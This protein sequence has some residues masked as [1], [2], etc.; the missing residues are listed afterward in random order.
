MRC[1]TE[2][3]KEL[4]VVVVVVLGV[5]VSRFTVEFEFEFEFGDLLLKKGILVF[6]VGGTRKEQHSKRGRGEGLVEAD[7]RKDNNDWRGGMDS[8]LWCY[9]Y[10][11]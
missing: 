4:P 7:Q 8:Y 3:A 2:R 6:Q 9:N 11:R 10:P 1:S 5:V